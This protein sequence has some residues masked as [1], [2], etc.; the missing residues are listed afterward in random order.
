MGNLIDDIKSGAINSTQGLVIEQTLNKL[1]YAKPDLDNE[2]EFLRIK[3]GADNN[4]RVGL[5][6]SAIIEAES[7]FCFREQVLSLFYKQLQDENVKIGL[8]RIF[9][10]GDS[11][12]EKWQRLFIRG[13]L[14]EPTNC[15]RTRFIDKFDLSFTPDISNVI[16]GNTEY[17]VEIK[18]MNTFQF[19]NAKTH[20]SGVKQL[21]FYMR[22]CKC[23]HGFVLMEDK[24]DQNFKIV[25]VVHDKE[26]TQPFVERLYT[27]QEFKERF[28][29]D[30]QMV[31]RTCDKSSC[32]RALV[33]NMRDACFNIG[34]G[35]IRL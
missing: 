25:P 9:T 18:S 24:N 11:I 20:P 27:I 29:R 14:A 17:I 23:K 8:K 28:T 26:V 32:K 10:E 12:H 21:Q 7:H 13:G 4:D 35:R 5:H 6:A 19:K 2:L 30:K 3:R 15:D 16:I 22:L 1:F 33:C 31:E 34:T